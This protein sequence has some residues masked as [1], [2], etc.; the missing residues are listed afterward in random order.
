ME[1]VSVQR[2][3]G[4]TTVVQLA[5]AYDEGRERAAKMVESVV[6]GYADHTVNQFSVKE[7]NALADRIRNGD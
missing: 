2:F 1:R 6:A 3:R 5:D 4:D 7:I